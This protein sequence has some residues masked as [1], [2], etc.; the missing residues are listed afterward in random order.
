MKVQTQEK[1]LNY[2]EADSFVWLEHSWY[3]TD[4]RNKGKLV[5][6]GRSSKGLLVPFLHHVPAVCQELYWAQE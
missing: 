6:R 1:R 2:V 5:N 3:G 4:T